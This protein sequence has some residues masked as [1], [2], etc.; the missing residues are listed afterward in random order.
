MKR[1][2]NRKRH[3]PEEVVAKLRQA[4]EALA[5]RVAIA[6]VARSLGVSE[7]TLHRWRTFYNHRRIQRALGKR[8]P[9]AFA[10]RC[11]P[12]PARRLAPLA[13]AAAQKRR[14]RTATIR[15]LA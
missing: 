13:R 11:A 12:A 5:K 10:A 8:T 3:R 1:P 6:E 15:K 7:V 4:D 14:T 9:A 2:M